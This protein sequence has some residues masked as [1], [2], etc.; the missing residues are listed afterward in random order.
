MGTAY[1][2]SMVSDSL[3]LFLDA[4]NIRS[5]PGSGTVWNDL[6]SVHNNATSLTGVTY[7]SN[8]AGYLTF[9]GSTGSGLLTSS[10]YN[11]TYTGK[12]IFVMGNCTGLSVGQYRAMIGTPTGTTAR[13]FNFYMYSPGSNTYQFHFYSNS[14]GVNSANLPYTL[15][16]WFM[17]AVTQ[18][19]GG[20]VTFYFNGVSAGTASLALAQ[21]Q[22]GGTDNGGGLYFKGRISTV[23]VYNYVFTDS[24]IIQNFNA[25]RWRYGV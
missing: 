8:N 4:A 23:H 15:G 6:S 22:S 5:Y 25:L 3:L 11:T 10:L 19:S 14:G 9:D 21:Y 24:L 7:N 12:T 20:N 16:N 2:P 1:G 13:N 18:S 17:G